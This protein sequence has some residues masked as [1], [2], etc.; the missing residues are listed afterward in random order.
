MVPVDFLLFAI[1]TRLGGR[2]VSA[3]AGGINVSLQAPSRTKCSHNRKY[4]DMYA[5][6]K[7]FSAAALRGGR[8][9][10]G[11]IL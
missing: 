8:T 1:A 4:V 10:K 2:L 3:V 11:D 5:C 6:A 9:K 7:S